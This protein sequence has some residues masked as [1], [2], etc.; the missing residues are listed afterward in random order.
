MTGPWSGWM[1]KYDMAFL[2]TGRSDK[3]PH[4]IRTG[5]QPRRGTLLARAPH[6]LVYTVY[7]SS[8]GVTSRVPQR[9]LDHT[10]VVAAPAEARL[11]VDLVHGVLGQTGGHQDSRALSKPAEKCFTI[12][13]KAKIGPR[14]K[15]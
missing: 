13:N 4:S 14:K 12:Q 11:G 7:H 15:F 6:V 3:L 1:E 9:N 2:I 8:Q 10:D 5:P